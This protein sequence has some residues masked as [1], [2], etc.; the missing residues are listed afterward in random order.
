MNHS[1][2][3]LL[4]CLAAAL[5]ISSCA[6]GGEDTPEDGGDKA[7]PD[8]T[9]D[10]KAGGEEDGADKGDGADEKAEKEAPA[11]KAAPSNAGAT[12]APVG[13]ESTWDRYRRLAQGEVS[14]GFNVSVVT[15]ALVEG[16]GKNRYGRSSKGVVLR[17]EGLITNN[18]GKTLYTG[19]LSGALVLRFGGEV[20]KVRLGKNGLKPEASDAKPWR[21]GRARLFK[22]ETFVNPTILMEYTPDSAEARLFAAFEDPIEYEVLA[23]IWSAK[24]DWL[25]VRGAAVNG[26][27]TVFKAEGLRVG[28]RGKAAGKTAVNE[29]V[30]LLYAQGDHYRV[31]AAAGEGWVS[32]KSLIVPD[33]KGLFNGAK[34]HGSGK[35]AGD[36]LVS[37]TVSSVTTTTTFPDGMKI[38][39]LEGERLFIA[40]VKLENKGE[41]DIKCSS[42]FVDYGPKAQTGPIKG[43]NNV[44]GAIACEGDK[45]APGLSASGKVAFLRK[46]HQV[47]FTVGY[48]S[49]SKG[50]PFVDIYSIKETEPYI[51]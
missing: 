47:P 19:F 49:P 15:M 9:G 29:K 7:T 26:K 46:R 28:P 20:V 43:W 39:T 27:G 14:D 51:K 41:K 6:C 44:S 16:K 12:G 33:L 36:D 48:S 21:T 23:P 8:K 34:P 42:F 38:K 25:A 24:I 45:L 37:I 1:T 2:G 10:E 22:V 5:L 11:P 18:T 32:Q 35:T 4:M 40:D 3:T 30:D 17:L 13:Y 31:R 50:F